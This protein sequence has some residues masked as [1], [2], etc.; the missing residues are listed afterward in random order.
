MSYSGFH[1]GRPVLVQV[2]RPSGTEHPKYSGTVYGVNYGSLPNTL[3]PDGGGVDAYILGV[4]ESLPRGELF[5]GECVALIHRLGEDDDKLIVVPAGKRSLRC[6]MEL[7]KEQLK[8]EILRQT[9]F[10]ER[11]FESELVWEFDDC[12]A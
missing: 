1:L 12:M 9:F 5:W 8:A 2:G 6:L 11:Y 10:Q 4:S 3:A 7:F